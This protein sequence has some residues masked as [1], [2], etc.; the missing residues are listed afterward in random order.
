MI[1]TGPFPVTLTDRR[2]ISTASADASASYGIKTSYAGE[3]RTL[4][5]IVQP[6][7]GR[8]DLLEWIA[9]ARDFVRN[10]LLKH[11]GILFRNFRLRSAEHFQ[12]AARV[13]SPDLLEYNERSSPRTQVSGN[14][15][16]STEYP[17][18]QAIPQHNENSYA[19]KWPMKIWFY[20][21]QAALRGGETPISDS[22]R[23]YESLS[24]PVRNEFTRKGVMYV[25]NFGEGIDLP[26]QTAFNT[27]H[28]SVVEAY[29]HNAGIQFRWKADGAL[30]TQQ[31][32]QAT[33]V[34]P[35]TGDRL[36]FNQAHL[37]HVSS[38]GKELEQALLA[39]MTEEELPRNTYYGD[40]SRIPP[41]ALAEIRAAYDSNLVVFSWIKGDVLLLDNML[42]AHGRMPFQ[43]ERRVMVAMAE[44]MHARSN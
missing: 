8:L 35:V 30:W 42:V 33:A 1:E 25:R 17:A 31:V 36:W 14:I 3:G 23:V 5:L 26:W 4:P 24:E 7:R 34:H 22:R 43:G 32:R 41:E 38:L 10:E 16:T 21:A 20:C 12:E 9:T 40:G 11:G 2:V 18:H 44:S 39:V 28:R 19:S 6:E 15:Y 29:C 37:F 27:T 13:I